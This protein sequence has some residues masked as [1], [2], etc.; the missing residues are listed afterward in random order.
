MSTLFMILVI[1]GPLFLFAVV[2]MGVRLIFPFAFCVVVGMI[3]MMLFVFATTAP[4]DASDPEFAIN[5][6]SVAAAV[7]VVTAAFGI[8]LLGVVVLARWLSGEYQSVK[9][10]SDT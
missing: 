10:G 7:L 4:P 1:I 3:G 2:R 8:F 5:P 6:V 9:E